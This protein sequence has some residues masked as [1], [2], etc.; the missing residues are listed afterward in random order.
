MMN[1][2]ALKAKAASVGVQHHRQ[3]KRTHSITMGFTANP[4]PP[5]GKVPETEEEEEAGDLGSDQEEILGGLDELDE[6]PVGNSTFVSTIGGVHRADPRSVS[7]GLLADELQQC[8]DDVQQRLQSAS[9]SSRREAEQVAESC[10]QQLASYA[11]KT[12]WLK[13][14]ST[15][16]TDMVIW[17]EDL[18]NGEPTLS[19]RARTAVAAMP[20]DEAAIRSA[21]TDDLGFDPADPGNRPETPASMAASEEPEP[22]PEQVV[23]EEVGLPL[24][25]TEEQVYAEAVDAPEPDVPEPEPEPEPEPGA[26]PE[27]EEADAEPGAEDAAPDADTSARLANGEMASDGTC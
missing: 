20:S 23:G 18:A 25:T 24:M 14:L 8:L 26:G 6:G 15:A 27:P 7:S 19:P 5:G 13:G 3:W 9:T 2:A 17:A 12:W 4:P 16:H 11:P 22:E 21:I 10:L 1:F